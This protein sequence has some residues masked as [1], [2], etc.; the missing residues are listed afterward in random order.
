MT[1]NKQLY[2][3]V[4]GKHSRIENGVRVRYMAGQ[5][6]V[7]TNEE[8]RIWGKKLRPVLQGVTPEPQEP[9]PKEEG[10]GEPEPEPEGK[11]KP[12]RTAKN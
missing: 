1:E 12:K 8:I 11:G 3:V 4:G 9:E 5:T 10:G 6:F 2:E 7:P